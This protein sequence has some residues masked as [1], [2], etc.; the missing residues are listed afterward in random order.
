MGRYFKRTT[1]SQQERVNR[2]DVVIY[3]VPSRSESCCHERRILNAKKKT[4]RRSKGQSASKTYVYPHSSDTAAATSRRRL[5]C[6]RSKRSAANLG[7]CTIHADNALLN[8]VPEASGNFLDT[9]GRGRLTEAHVFFEPMRDSSSTRSENCTAPVYDVRC[10]YT[11]AEKAT[12]SRTTGPRGSWV[13]CS[14]FG[15]RYERRGNEPKS[16]GMP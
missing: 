2:D 9:G 8:L 4:V 6:C 5:W 7:A 13:E 10:G 16:R 15:D 1:E 14:T 11:G 3:S 12:L